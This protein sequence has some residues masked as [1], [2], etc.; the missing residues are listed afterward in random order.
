MTSAPTCAW[1][2]D[3]ETWVSCS[4]CERPI[5]PSCMNEA[6]VGF[7][8][9]GCIAEGRATVRRIK[10]RSTPI[11]NLIIGICVAVFAYG[12]LID[13]QLVLKFGLAPIAITEFGEYYR[14]IT[15]MFLHGGIIH[16][17][18]NMLI[19]HQLGTQLEYFFGSP[20]FTAIY[21]FAGLGGGLASL[22]FNAPFVL[23]VGASGAIF[24]LMGAYLVVAQQIR[25]DARSIYG[26]LGINLVIGFIVPGIDWHAHLGGLAAGALATAVIHRLFPNWG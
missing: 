26:L 25:M 10:T 4:R 9:P 15:A 11:T 23:S 12:E 20:K 22:V 5:C 19:L 13:S 16:L 17:V 3:R 21:L 1:H 8:C 7:H 24:G 6:P 14:M 2:P 18:F